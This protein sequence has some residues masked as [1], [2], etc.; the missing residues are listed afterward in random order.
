MSYCIDQSRTVFQTT[1]LTFHDPS[2]LAPL[3]VISTQLTAAFAYFFLIYPSIP[4]Q[5]ILQLQTLSVILSVATLCSKRI[6][7]FVFSM[8]TKHTGFASLLNIAFH[9]K[10]LILWY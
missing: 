3:L 10:Q 2:L 8:V 5:P 7:E 9:Q 1:S 6:P 4:E